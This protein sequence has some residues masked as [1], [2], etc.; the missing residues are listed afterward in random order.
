M[1]GKT[2]VVG[3][4]GNTGSGVAATL[5]ASG[6]AVR[7]LVR[8]EAK[9]QSLKDGGAEVVVG[10]LDKPETLTADLFEGIDNVYLCI[11]NGPSAQQEGENF[12]DALAKS[13]AQPR[14]VRLSAFGSPKSRIIQQTD[15]VDAKLAASGLRYTSLKPTFF[16][17]NL[18]MAGPTIQD[19]GGMY[20]DWADGKAGI[21]DVRDIVE[22]AVGAI[23]AEDGRFDGETLVLTGPAS[24]GMAEA[25]AA[26]SKAIG[27]D[28]NYVAVPHEAAKEAMVGMGMPEW[29][30]DGFIELNEGF[31][32][33]FADKVTD[34]V[35]RLTGHAPRS[36]ESFADD[37][38]GAFGG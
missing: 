26:I 35:Q 31:E 25:A 36:V 10:D 14:I 30:V 8:D 15:K 4:T 5:L 28:V 2:L 24:V 38:K 21:I 1:A 23:E 32:A 3:A 6:N 37:F 16:M 19:H 29:I 17:Q 18:M 9:A 20:F 7:A 27:K 34:G 13:G 22:S 12:L 11:W 33:G